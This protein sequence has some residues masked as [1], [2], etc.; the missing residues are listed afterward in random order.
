M[1]DILFERFAALAD[2]TD[3]SDWLDVRRRARHRHL[4]IAVAAA[5]AVAVAVVT[6]GLAATGGWVFS[7]HDHKVTAAAT[8]SLNGKTWNVSVTSMRF[9][10]L[11]F[12]VAGPGGP[13]PTCSGPLGTL[14]RA[15]PLGAVKVNVP[16]GQI[17][18]GATIGFTRRVAITNDRGQMYTTDTI[19]APKTTKTPFRYWA[20]AVAGTAESLTAYD[21]KGHSIRKSLR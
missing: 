10:R 11:C 15:R 4:Q 6:A 17:W 2:L 18:L 20:L 16:G 9:G 19:A 7:T 3:D 12:R 14:V 1:T 5:A 8:V 21:A 13:A